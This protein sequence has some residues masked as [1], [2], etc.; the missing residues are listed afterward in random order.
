ML[1]DFKFF[2]NIWYRY[3]AKSSGTVTVWYRTK[4]FT[5][6]HVRLNGT[7]TGTQLPVMTKKNSSY[8]TVLLTGENGT[9]ADNLPGD[10]A[11]LSAVCL[12][13]L[14]QIAAAHRV[15]VGCTQ[16]QAVNDGPLNVRRKFNRPAELRLLLRGVLVHTVVE[17]HAGHHC[18]LCLG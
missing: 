18:F 5:L 3:C 11:V 17:S 6:I 8:I 10:H 2:L 9:G 14:G 4:L 16:H 12:H 7:G 13:K 15:L 1:L